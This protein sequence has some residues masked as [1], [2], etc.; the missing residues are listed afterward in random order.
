MCTV[1]YTKNYNSHM[2]PRTCLKIAQCR[3]SKSDDL[4]FMADIKHA[5][6]KI[7]LMQ[8]TDYWIRFLNMKSLHFSLNPEMNGLSLIALG[9]LFHAFAPEQIIEFLA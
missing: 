7:S 5:M 2:D 8:P 3:H 6:S 4:A 1:G 9:N